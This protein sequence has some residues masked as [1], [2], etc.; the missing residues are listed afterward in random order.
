MFAENEFIP[1][2]RKISS[3]AVEKKVSE[4]KQVVKKMRKISEQILPV[5]EL[6]EKVEM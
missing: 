3:D 5:H 4:S 2:P 1:K 6:E